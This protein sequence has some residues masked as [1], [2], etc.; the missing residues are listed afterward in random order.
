M[1]FS[2]CQAWLAGW[3]CAAAAYP[4]CL[5]DYRQPPLLVFDKKIGRPAR[6]VEAQ[7]GLWFVT[8]AMQAF[9]ERVDPAVCDFRKGA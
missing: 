9:L 6:D 4:W 2:P 5:P 8:S 1:R 7:D 3:L